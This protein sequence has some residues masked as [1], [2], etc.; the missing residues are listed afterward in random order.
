ME[1]C[2]LCTLLHLEI[3]TEVLSTRPL[4]DEE[5]YRRLGEA[6]EDKAYTNNTGFMAWY[7]EKY[8]YDK[9]FEFL[10]EDDLLF[11]VVHDQGKKVVVTCVSAKTHIAGKSLRS[12][13]KFNKVKTKEEKLLASLSG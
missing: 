11:V 2:D 12:R 10:V 7:H 5:I 13:P 3:K 1:E 4:I 9:R 8:G 6:E